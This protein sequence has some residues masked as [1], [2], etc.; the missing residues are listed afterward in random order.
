[1]I[2]PILIW[3]LEIRLFIIFLN[4][5]QIYYNYNIEA[6]VDSLFFIE[7]IITIKISY[8]LIKFIN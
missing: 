3:T 7:D 8:L 1:M 4:S 6:I 2:N 5:S